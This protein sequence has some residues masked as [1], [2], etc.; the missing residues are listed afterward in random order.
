MPGSHN[1]ACYESD[2]ALD[3]LGII[4][5][6]VEN[7]SLDV[8]EQLDAGVRLSDVHVVTDRV[9]HSELNR[10]SRFTI[11]SLRAIRYPCGYVPVN[12]TRI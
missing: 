11:S 5:G 6:L 2:I 4:S 7:Q 1:A 8:Y 3:V 10:P 9:L 12:I